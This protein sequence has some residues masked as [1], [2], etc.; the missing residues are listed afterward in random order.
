M[1]FNDGTV[2]YYGTSTVYDFSSSISPYTKPSDS[3]R[4]LYKRKTAKIRVTTDP[5][6]ALYYADKSVA[7]HGGEPIIYEVN[8]DRFT[9]IKTSKNGYSTASADVVG[10]I[11]YND[12]LYEYFLSKFIVNNTDADFLGQA[13]IEFCNQIKISESREDAMKVINDKYREN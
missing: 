6:A 1:K 4:T 10:V 3:A 9:M 13:F 5:D 2:F 11:P 7:E 12:V 8:P